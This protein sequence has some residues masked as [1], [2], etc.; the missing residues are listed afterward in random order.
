MAKVVAVHIENKRG[1]KAW[2]PIAGVL[3]LAIVV[4]GTLSWL[5]HRSSQP[6]TSHT[7]QPPSALQNIDAQRA[8]GDNTSANI[9]ITNALKD[10]TISADTKYQLYIDKGS[11]AEDTGDLHAALDAFNNAAAIK[12]V[13][14]TYEAIASIYTSLGDKQN[15]ITAYKKAISL[16]PPNY[17]FAADEKAA[18][19]Q[20]IKDLGGT[21]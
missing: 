21:P 6:K 8:R 17:M 7:S 16:I 15:A 3:L 10:P 9:L 2:L 4:G 19:Q 20:K 12:Q 1:S 14:T 18:Y 13:Y 5:T 11:V